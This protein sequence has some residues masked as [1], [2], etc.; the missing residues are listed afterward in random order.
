MQKHHSLTTYPSNWPVLFS[1]LGHSLR[2]VAVSMAP[3]AQLPAQPPPTFEVAS[4]KRVRTEGLPRGGCRGVDS[5]YPAELRAS[6]PPLGR[7]VLTDASLEQM[8]SSAYRL[9]SPEP[10]KGGPSWAREGGLHFNIEGKAEDPAKATEA[11]LYQMFQALLIERFQIKLHMETREAPGFALV[12][13]KNGPKLQRTPEGEPWSYKIIPGQPMTLS[14]RKLTMPWFAGFLKSCLANSPV[15]DMT[16]L[17]GAYD[18]D[19]SWDQQNGPSIITA[20][21]ELGLRLQPQKVP[22]PFL[23]IESAQMPTEN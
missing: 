19:L 7:C 2:G 4:V 14:A 6:A 15:I 20:L 11:Q 23:V 22:E 17:K 5:T 13:A 8:L 10:V 12:I 9:H 18:I 21:H 16:E 1:T 3:M